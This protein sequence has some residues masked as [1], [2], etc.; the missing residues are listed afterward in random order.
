MSQTHL[1]IE[2]QL[3][4]DTTRIVCSITDEAEARKHVKDLNNAREE[5]YG[6]PTNVFEIES[7]L[8]YDGPVPTHDVIEFYTLLYR[9]DIL[10][11]DLEPRRFITY[12][13]TGRWRRELTVDT[14]APYIRVVVRTSDGEEEF[15]RM[16][17]E[18]R[19][20]VLDARA[21]QTVSAMD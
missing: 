11:P 10:S 16:L 9:N 6:R 14:S 18:A 4:S 3:L 12:D 15:A 19:Q 7:P 8:A 5:F 2:R 21:T 20:L 17:A 13:H 1:I